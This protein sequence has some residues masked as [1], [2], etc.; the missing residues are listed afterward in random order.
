MEKHLLAYKIFLS[1]LFLPK[2]N[3]SGY[4]L[5][6]LPFSFNIVEILP[7]ECVALSNSA[8]YCWIMCDG[9]H[10]S[11][12]SLWWHFFD[13]YWGIYVAAVRLLSCVRLFAAP[14][15]AAHQAPCPSPSPRA[16]SN[17]CPSSRWCHPTISS[18]VIPF[19]SCLQ[20]FQ[21]QGLFQGVSSS[22]QV[23][24]VLVVYLHFLVFPLT[25]GSHSETFA[26]LNNF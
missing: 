15:P 20:A 4:M 9:S 25:Y 19:S 5:W 12:T 21:L 2:F 11:L 14:R 10:L 22:H 24:K 13:D 8:F 3:K 1:A 6:N 18:S 16:C 23:A 26:L 17:S 7:C